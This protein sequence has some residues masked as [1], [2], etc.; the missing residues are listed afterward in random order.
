MWNSTIV[1]DKPIL[2]GAL[3]VPITFLEVLSYA[4]TVKVEGM[5]VSTSIPMMKAVL[6]G[7]TFSADPLSM[8]TIGTL[9]PM[10]SVVIYKGLVRVVLSKVSSS[11][12][13]VRERWDGASTPMRDNTSCGVVSMGTFFPFKLSK[14]ALQCLWEAVSKP[15]MDTWAWVFF[16]WDKT[17]SS[18]SFSSLPLK[19]WVWILLLCSYQGD[20]SIKGWLVVFPTP[21]NV[22]NIVLKDSFLQLDHSFRE[23]PPH[24][25]R[26]DTAF[27]TPYNSGS[28]SL[29]KLQIDLRGVKMEN[30]TFLSK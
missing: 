13:E 23:Y 1:S 16:N 15:H 21:S 22:C 24:S 19:P 27:C 28:H 18:S 29:I 26:V 12:E 9:A 4:L 2:Q 14:R 11:T 7:H 20:H 3:K 25:H 17:L 8:S 30:I 5:V 10:H 6:K